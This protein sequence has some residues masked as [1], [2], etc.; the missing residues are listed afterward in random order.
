GIEGSEECDDGN[1]DDGDGCSST[2]TVENGWDCTGRP[3]V[4]TTTCGDGAVAGSEECDDENADDGDGCSSSCTVEVGWNC[5]GE[6]S[7]CTVKDGW[8]CTG[9][10]SVCTTTCGDGVNAGSEECDDDN[11]DDDDGCSSTC[12]VEDGCACSGEPSMCACRP[13]EPPD[14]NSRKK[15]RYISFDPNNPGRPVKLKV[16]LTDSLPH[17]GSV[18]NSWWAQAPI[19]ADAG[20]PKPLLAAGEC[21]ALLGPEVT[22]AALDWDAAGCQ[23]LH[24]TGCPIEPTSEYEVQAVVDVSPSAALMVS[25][26]LKPGDKWWGDTVGNFDSV[27]WTPPQGTTNID[28]AVAA[29]KTFQGGQV[30]PPGPVPPGNVAHLAVTDIHPGDV[31]TIVNA[32]DVLF[33]ILAFQ[34][35]PYPFGPADTDGNCP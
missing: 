6:P 19:V 35:E 11:L 7:V 29:I 15:N 20:A 13:V 1:P 18:G 4:C 8:T 14:S 2:C 25:T 31:N 32:N 21:A 5:T 12:T 27:E 10:P 26:I 34:G 16:T 22:A 24:V 33:V 30:V 17:P 3:S 28:D 23:T 9:E